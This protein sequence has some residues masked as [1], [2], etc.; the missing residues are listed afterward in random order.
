MNEKSIDKKNVNSK[1]SLELI[2]SL[3]RKRINELFGI[4]EVEEKT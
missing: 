4:D 3:K 2:E 1:T